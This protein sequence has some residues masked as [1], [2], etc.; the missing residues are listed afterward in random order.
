VSD[1]DV[2]IVGGGISGLA[3]AWWLTRRGLE[4]ELWECAQRAGGKIRTDNVAGYTSERAAALVLNYRPEVARLL[5]ES[6]LDVYKATPLTRRRYLVDQNRL[7]PV[8]T[9]LGEMVSS[10]LWSCGAKLRLLAEPFIPRGQREDET[11][12]E[13]V[14]RRLG[15]E[16]LDKAMEP[17]VAGT[18]AADPDRASA[19]AVLP[20][21]TAFE[22]HYGSVTV[23]ALMQRLRSRRRTCPTESFSFVGGMS[24][25]IEALARTSGVHLRL[26]RAVDALVPDG[27]GGWLVSATSTEGACVLKARH[28]VLSIPAG[29]A[30]WLL[31]SLDAELAVLLGGI[32]YSPVCVLHF[33]FNRDAVRHPLNGVGF[34]TAREPRQPLNGV[35]WMSTLF[36]GRAPPGKV[37]LTCYLGGAR[38]PDVVDWNEERVTAAVLHGLKTLLGLSAE[39]EMVQ[40]HRH[41]Q[42]LPLYHGAYLERM[43]RIDARLQ[44]FPGLHLAANYVGG[45]SVRDRI[46]CGSEVADK[47]LSMAG[48]FRQRVGWTPSAA[49]RWSM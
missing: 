3:S 37:L 11:V 2:L 32:E 7:L 45:V 14:T 24:T 35:L 33:G 22:R 38:A 16:P 1:T 18:L 6:G 43:R 27:A 23:G 13:F 5:S 21:L 8:P 48:R 19:G 29:V 44:R 36:P 20:R 28:V 4:V 26:G 25:L 41:H 17:Y 10:P 15:R 9:R 49:L 40:I 42:A 47:I 30:A 34:L 46:V 39:P 31:R 12:S